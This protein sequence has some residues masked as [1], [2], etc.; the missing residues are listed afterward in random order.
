MKKIIQRVLHPFYKRYHFWYHSK[1]RKFK[2]KDV[3]TIIQPG[4]FSPKHTISTTVFL[5]FIASLE[6]N[7][8]SLL[9]LGCGSGIISLHSAFK[10]AKVTASDINETALKSLSE[11]SNSQGLKITTIYSDF[12][13]NL[14]N[15]S[16]DYILIN[17][18]YYPK[19]PESIAESAWFCGL[20]FE[21]FEQ[22][23]IDL[24]KPNLTNSI[25]YMILSDA[26][27]F[28]NIQKIANKNGLSLKQVHIRKLTFETNFIFQVTLLK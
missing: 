19:A 25:I 15:S 6:L 12:F 16:F 28:Q 24:G 5:D 14:P 3:Y 20:D 23:F 1:P 8:K 26:C 7:N 11:V 13:N 2:Y 22:L 17:P 9:E 27:D 10:G 18:P 4:V 21:Y